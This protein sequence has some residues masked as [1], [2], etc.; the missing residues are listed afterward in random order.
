M[1]KWQATVD[2][3]PVSQ[4]RH[5]FNRFTGAVYYD[6]ESTKYRKQVVAAFKKLAPAKPVT[7]PLGLSLLIRLP[8]PHKL[9]CHFEKKFVLHKGKVVQQ[10]K[11]VVDTICAEFTIC[12]KRMWPDSRGT[13]D[14]SNITKQVE[15]ALQEAKVIYDDA[16]IVEY[17][18]PY[19]KVWSDGEGS[20]TVTLSRRT[21][22]ADAAYR[23][24][25]ALPK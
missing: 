23:R 9:R 3:K 6:A 11:R 13:P 7:F 10:R 21:A 15:D 17:L 5:H 1:W 12:G 14:L 2:G 16:C 19:R 25:D 20:I 8:R 4:D 24:T 18:P 22:P